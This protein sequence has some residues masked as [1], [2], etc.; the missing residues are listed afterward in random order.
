M[1]DR[2]SLRAAY[3]AQMRRWIP[4]APQ[5]G[6]AYERIGEL[7]R[8]C[9]GHRGFVDT[10]PDVGVR[11]DELDRLIT[12]QRDFFAARGEAVEWKI[13][14]HDRPAD[15]PERLAAAGFEPEDE[16][17]VVVALAAEMTAMPRLPDGVVIRRVSD[18]VDF[19]RL[20]DMESRV[21]GAPHDW[22]AD[23][24]HGRAT[25]DPDSLAVYVV[26]ADGEV[27]CGAWVEF[28]PG[29][30]FAGLWGGSTLPAWRGRGLHRALVGVRA[31]LAV[32]RSVPYLQVDASSESRP[33][34]ERLGFVAITT[35]TPYVFTPTTLLVPR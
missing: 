4:A 27:V 17:T 26:E 25:S 1:I 29:T 11:G 28:K 34:L 30:D 9:G 23:D 14:G 13:R 5:P 15:L 24:L 22:I 3:D 8:V 31:R 2:E 18:E 16:E 10:A 35:T 19:G 33:I 12:A 7:L 20:A 6:T 32:E 21:W